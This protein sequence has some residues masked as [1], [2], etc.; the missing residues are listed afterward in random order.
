[1]IPTANGTLKRNALAALPTLQRRTL[2]LTL[3][4]LAVVA[5]VVAV[6][7]FVMVVVPETLGVG[8]SPHL[9]HRV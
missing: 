6:T 5:V 1:M 4:P 8:F 7:A 3:L 9:Q 2:L